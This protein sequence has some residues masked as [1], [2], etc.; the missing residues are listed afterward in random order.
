MTNKELWDNA[1]KCR[2]YVKIDDIM[3]V[4]L[5]LPEVIQAE[6][7]Y[8]LMSRFSKLFRKADIGNKISEDI[9]TEPE[10][11]SELKTENNSNG[12]SKGKLIKWSEEEFAFLKGCADSPI[13]EI[14]ARLKARFGVNRTDSAILN[15]FGQL[16]IHR[17]GRRRR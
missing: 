11:E 15:K 3:S 6:E 14:R 9:V 7:F 17:L 16:G 12:H 13:V 4:T 8:G 1:R 10:T 5:D 2:H